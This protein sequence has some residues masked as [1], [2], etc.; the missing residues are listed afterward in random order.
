MGSRKYIKVTCIKSI[1]I[2][3]STKDTKFIYFDK[4]DLYKFMRANINAIEPKD[5][6]NII[7]AK[8][9]LNIAKF[10]KKMFLKK[11]DNIDKTR[12]KYPKMPKYI[13]NPI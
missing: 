1:S 3:V 12:A 10:I 8:T 6:L 4:L 7:I 9:E 13:K 11:L 5:E 2:F